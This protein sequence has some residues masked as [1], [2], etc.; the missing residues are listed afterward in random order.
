[1]QISRGARSEDVKR[2]VIHA[3]AEHKSPRA[4]AKLLDLARTAE[5]PDVR[6]HAIHQLG[7]RTPRRW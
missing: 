4:E 3:L 7:E 1:M 6:K 5:P 2:T